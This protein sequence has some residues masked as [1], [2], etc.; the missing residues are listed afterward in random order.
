[1]FEWIKRTNKPHSEAEEFK[2]KPLPKEWTREQVEMYY[3]EKFRKLNQELRKVEE[4][5]HDMDCLERQKDQEL[6]VQLRSMEQ[7]EREFKAQLRDM[8]LKDQQRE[9]ELR[10]QLADLQANYERL[11]QKVRDYMGQMQD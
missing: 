10:A 9:Q 5:L 4:Q 7:K 11:E 6:Q 2:L 3:S 8:E 1:M